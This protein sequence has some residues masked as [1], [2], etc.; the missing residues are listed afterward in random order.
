MSAPL[1]FT[2]HQGATWQRTVILKNPD[3][4]VM[5][6]TGCT[7][8]MQIRSNYADFAGGAPLADLTTANGKIVITAL[9]GK[10]V[11]TISAAETQTFTWRNAFYDVEVV[12]ADATIRRILE[13][14][15]E[16]KPEVTR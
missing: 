15:V 1:N 16:V 12:F 6:L 5:N 11:L 4:T 9:E 13:G 10:I 3:G 8:R 2:I 7:A 14:R